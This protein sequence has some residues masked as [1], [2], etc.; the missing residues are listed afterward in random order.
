M[1][2]IAVTSHGTIRGRSALV[3]AA[4]D[5]IESTPQLPTPRRGKELLAAVTLPLSDLAYAA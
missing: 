2:T 1:T 3:A 4:V 5:I